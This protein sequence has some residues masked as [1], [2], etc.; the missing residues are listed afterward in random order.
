LKNSKVQGVSSWLSSWTYQAGY[1][2]GFFPAPKKPHVVP[3]NGCTACCKLYNVSVPD[4]PENAWMDTVPSDEPGERILRRNSDGSC[5]YLVEEKCA[6]RDR[7]PNECRAYDCRTQIVAGVASEELWKAIGHKKDLMLAIKSHSDKIAVLAVKLSVF[8]LARHGIRTAEKLADAACLNAI[9]KR[10]LATAMFKGLMAMEE[11]KP[12][13]LEG[14]VNKF[15][16]DMRQRFP[17][18]RP[19]VEGIFGASEKEEPSS[20][21]G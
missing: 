6:I 4:T 2:E 7:R 5:V 8:E 18:G 21:N 20:E 15:E 19:T 1:L 17:D 3:C 9:N 14:M 13:T 10:D 11:K 16:A 12:G